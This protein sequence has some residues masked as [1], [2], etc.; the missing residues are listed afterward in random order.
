MKKI[1]LFMMFLIS[2]NF[3]NAINPFYD[4]FTKECYYQS[5]VFSF[6][7]INSTYHYVYNS[8]SLQYIPFNSLSQNI[9]AFQIPSNIL[10]SLTQY[11]LNL[12]A[13]NY[14][15][16]QF[17]LINYSSFENYIFV[18]YPS[19]TFILYYPKNYSCASTNASFNYVKNYQNLIFFNPNLVNY[20]NTF[21]NGFDEVAKYPFMLLIPSNLSE[22]NLSFYFT[23]SPSYQYNFYQ[24]ISSNTLYNQIKSEGTISSQYITDIANSINLYQNQNLISFY[25]FNPIFFYS[26]NSILSW[27]GLQVLRNYSIR[28]LSNIIN[29]Q[30]SLN[31]NF[32]LVLTSNKNNTYLILP[33]PSM[34]LSNYQVINNNYTIVKKNTTS[35]GGYQYKINFTVTNWNENYSFPYNKSLYQVVNT[36]YSVISIPN[37]TQ[38]SSSYGPFTNMFINYSYKGVNY[39]QVNFCILKN[40]TIQNVYIV[41]TRKTL[42]N[43][44]IANNTNIT[45][46][47]GAVNPIFWKSYDNQTLCNTFMQKLTAGQILY[48]NIKS[49]ELSQTQCTG[50]NYP[51]IIYLNLTVNNPL[52]FQEYNSGTLNIYLYQTATTDNLGIGSHNMYSNAIKQFYY[53]PNNVFLFISKNLYVNSPNPQFYWENQSGIYNTF[54]SS[55]WMCSFYMIANSTIYYSPPFSTNVKVFKVQTNNQVVN[56]TSSSQ[57]SVNILPNVSINTNSSNLVNASINNIVILNQTKKIILF[58]TTINP[59]LLLIL[60]IIAVFVIGIAIAYGNIVIISIVFILFSIVFSILNLGVIGITLIAMFVLFNIIKE[61]RGEI[62][63]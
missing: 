50:F 31:A 9:Y 61:K 57:P 43:Y 20:F 60:L 15:N 14:S 38:L 17:V 56:T 13:Y 48:S 7:N 18:N 22:R 58:N 47:F 41:I 49:A 35:L 25:P 24:F 55:S 10:N 29:S 6:N 5:Y 39:G 27:S 44:M 21:E 37:Y 11:P 46:Y 45:I 59:F 23:D 34:F 54:T 2:L 16:D 53:N 40:S 1:I 32:N 8:N 33:F 26:N 12:Y 4:N 36:S 28:N 63:E 30:Y 3:V 52:Y 51:T 42:N 62:N 19:N